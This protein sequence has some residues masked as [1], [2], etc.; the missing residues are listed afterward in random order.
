MVKTSCCRVWLELA[1][2]WSTQ[3]LVMFSLEVSY[4]FCNLKQN[5][6]GNELQ[7]IISRNSLII[8]WDHNQKATPLQILNTNTQILVMEEVNINQNLT[9]FS[10]IKERVFMKGI[11]KSWSILDSLITGT[12]MCIFCI[13]LSFFL[14]I[15]SPLSFFT[16]L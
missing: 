11:E 13:H 8:N 10:F 12:N 5:I 4:D 6:S 7:Q 14:S 2:T 16:E 9:A 1:W 3:Y 15:W